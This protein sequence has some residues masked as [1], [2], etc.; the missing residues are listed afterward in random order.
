[1]NDIYP[2]AVSIAEAVRMANTSRTA[3]YYA[4]KRNELVVRKRGRRT[5]IEVDALKA[6]LSGLPHGRNGN[7]A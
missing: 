4:M 7:A 6:W 5:L 1:M 3:L 2:L